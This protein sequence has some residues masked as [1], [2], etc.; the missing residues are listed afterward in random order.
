MANSGRYGRTDLY[1]LPVI[2]YVK[3][4]ING[5]AALDMLLLF[6][7]EK[8]GAFFDSKR[9]KMALEV[10]QKLHNTRM[11]D[12]QRDTVIGVTYLL[13]IGRTFDHLYLCDIVC[14]RIIL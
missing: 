9:I 11:R 4:V 5:Q 6:E 7:R 14:P 3:V 1:D 12:I 13:C 2:P 8:D 10:V